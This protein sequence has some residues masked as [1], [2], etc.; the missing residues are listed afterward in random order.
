[1]ST[2]CEEVTSPQ[3]EVNHDGGH[4]WFLVLIWIPSILTILPTYKW[5][6]VSFGEDSVDVPQV[7][8]N[9]SCLQPDYGWTLALAHHWL[10][11]LLGE[12]FPWLLSSIQQSQCST[13]TEVQYGF[14]SM[15][16]P[17]WM[18]LPKPPN[19]SWGRIESFP[20]L[21]FW[22]IRCHSLK[23]AFSL[24]FMKSHSPNLCFPSYPSLRLFLGSFPSMMKRLTTSLLA[25]FYL[26]STSLQLSQG[27]FIYAHGFK[28]LPSNST[29]AQ[30]SPPGCTQIPIRCCLLDYP[31]VLPNKRVTS[32]TYHLLQ[33]PHFLLQTFTNICLPLPLFRISGNGLPCWSTATSQKSP[34][35][36][37]L[38][39]PLCPSP[40]PVDS[41]FFTFLSY[42]LYASTLWPPRFR[43][44]TCV[45]L[46]YFLFGL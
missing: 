25:T 29:S 16:H 30:T 20:C 11:W 3:L 12:G 24:T 21:T 17:L 6:G 33:Q 32:W 14:C 42:A 37:P 22:S 19:S 43:T 10:G 9:T 5:T 15:G 36:L 31:Q 1:M 41:A 7:H 13:F 40:T 46:V 8:F 39:H 27:H 45:F 38:L 35:S 4:S 28:M 23:Q 44:P 34:L 26:P 18:L 2:L